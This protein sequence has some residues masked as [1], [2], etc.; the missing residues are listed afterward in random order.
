ME[1]EGIAPHILNLGTRWKCVFSLT[2]RLHY[3]RGKNPRCPVDRGLRGPRNRSGRG[4]E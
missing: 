1:S 4:G 2:P 3:L